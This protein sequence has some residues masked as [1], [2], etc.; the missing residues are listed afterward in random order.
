MGDR[1]D[2]AVALGCD[3]ITTYSASAPLPKHVDELMLAGFFR[4]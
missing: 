4:G 3:P 1:L 2:V